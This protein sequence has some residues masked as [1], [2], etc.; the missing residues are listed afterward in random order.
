MSI[1]RGLAAIGLSGALVTGGAL[2]ATHEGKVN[3]VYLDPVGILTSCYGHTGPELQPGQ[4][5][6]DDQCLAQLAI[7]L[8]KHDKLLRSVVRVSMS[9][10]EHA[11]YLSAVYNYGIGNFRTSTA[12]KLLNEGRRKEACV[13]AIRF[14][15]S[16]RMFFKGLLNRRI[17]EAKICLKDL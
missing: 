4:T 3:Q 17:D 2:I 15:F 11:A 10:G 7:D 6:T 9:E 1:Q 12:L 13:E 16:G 14:V 8:V 5:F